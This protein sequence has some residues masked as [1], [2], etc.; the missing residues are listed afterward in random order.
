[1]SSQE[2]S[3]SG[4]SNL[5]C[6]L[7]SRLEQA[8]TEQEIEEIERLIDMRRSRWFVPMLADIAELFG[9]EVQTVREWRTG[10]QPMPGSE[11]RWNIKDI[12]QWRCDRLKAN[13]SVKSREVV[14]LELR[15]KQADV[16]KKELI[17]RQKRGDLIS[18]TAAKAKVF[19]ILN[20]ARCQLEAIPGIV[21][22]RV[23]PDHR[24]ELVN[25]WE[26]QI[27]LILRTMAAKAEQ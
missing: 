2:Q 20:D 21:G 7:L 25:E 10:P 19:E 11:G 4:N 6:D 15:E 1:M 13:S 14:E 8:Q 16:A 23:D 22:A 12:V 18:R 27:S 26:Q 17:V 5:D 3:S 24:D 9:V